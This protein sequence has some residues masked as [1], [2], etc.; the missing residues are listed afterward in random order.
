MSDSS[1]V[2]ALAGRIL[3][4]PPEWIPLEIAR[5]E[6]HQFLQI[7]NYKS[8]DHRPAFDWRRLA[9]GQISRSRTAIQHVVFCLARLI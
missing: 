9:I 3:L 1:V 2:R 6:F 4:K 5:G 8:P 7:F